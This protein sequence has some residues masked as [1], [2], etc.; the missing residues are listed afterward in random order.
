MIH[1]INGGLYLYLFGA[2]QLSQNFHLCLIT[3]QN[4]WLLRSFSETLSHPLP[5]RWVSLIWRRKG[6]GGIKPFVFTSQFRITPHSFPLV[7]GCFAYLRAHPPPPSPLCLWPCW[8]DVPIMAPVGRTRIW[9]SNLPM[10]ALRQELFC[11]LC[12]PRSCSLA[13]S[14]FLRHLL[15]VKAFLKYKPKPGTNFRKIFLFCGL[16][17][18]RL[19]EQLKGNPDYMNRANECGYFQTRTEMMWIVCCG[20]HSQDK[21]TQ[22]YKNVVFNISMKSPSSFCRRSFLQ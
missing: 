20:L 1:A 13:A 18:L 5:T 19:S 2:H 11:E 17:H 12:T 22:K 6:L 14:H 15:T 16:G 21:P 3:L 10:R 7:C 4:K 8:P 9:L